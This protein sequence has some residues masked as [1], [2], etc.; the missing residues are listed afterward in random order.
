MVVKGYHGADSNRGDP[1]GLAE[2][3]M[4]CAC[5]PGP[6]NGTAGAFSMVRRGGGRAA[7]NAWLASSARYLQV[8]ARCDSHVTG[9]AR[10]IPSMDPGRRSR[11]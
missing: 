7:Q 4:G 6:E 3:A 8:G 5:S 1:P 10:V 2:P 9:G 11:S